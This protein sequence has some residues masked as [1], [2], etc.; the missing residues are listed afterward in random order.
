M[1]KSIPIILILVILVVFLIQNHVQATHTPVSASCHITCT[2][3]PNIEGQRKS[4][5]FLLSN[6]NE[7]TQELQTPYN[8]SSTTQ[9]EN[10]IQICIL[11]ETQYLLHNS[12]KYIFRILTTYWR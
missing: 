7:G 5:S 12:K 8:K 2:V 11:V 6:I 1:K 10:D 4:D 3:L 9:L